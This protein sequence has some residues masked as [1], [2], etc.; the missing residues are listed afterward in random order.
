LFSF[1]RQVYGFDGIEPSALRDR[2]TRLGRFLGTR[3]FSH[4]YAGI[5]GRVHV[6]ETMMLSDDADGVAHYARVGADAL[7]NIEAAL[8]AAGTGWDEIRSC[9]DMGCG[10][11]RVLRHIARHVNPAAI[12]ACDLEEE[13][14]RFCAE[15]LGARPLLSTDDLRDLS[16]PGTYD[17]AWV[18]SLF[19][20]LPHADA[21][22]L[23]GKLAAALNPGGVLCFTTQGPSCLDHIAFYGPMFAP[24]EA[25]YRSQV[26]ARGWHY[27]PYYPSMPR[28][29]IMLYRRDEV[30]A[31]LARVQEGRLKLV[32][33]AER[34]WDNHQDC[35]A[36]RRGGA[37]P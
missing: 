36:F 17:L 4:A 5:P 2:Q 30:E 18:G 1:A 10:F 15:E 31:A 9:L 26:A 32:R 34:G 24:L 7:A 19:T 37:M 27:A 14:V 33:F 22:V 35:W 29:G 3:L 6:H 12:T 20:H 21:M 16:L 8:A 23:F 25:E 11:G 28:Y 13:A